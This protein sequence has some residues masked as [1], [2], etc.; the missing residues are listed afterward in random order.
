MTSHATPYL[1]PLGVWLALPEKA[2]AMAERV[3]SSLLPRALRTRLVQRGQA[4]LG[5]Q[6]AP[7][8]TCTWG[9]LG[10]EAL[11]L[12][13]CRWGGVSYSHLIHAA[14]ELNIQVIEDLFAE[15]REDVAP[16]AADAFGSAEETGAAE[17]GGR[18]ADGVGRGL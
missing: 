12:S 9:D 18:L 2:E 3:E 1:P 6:G 13:A 10:A 15:R 8:D 7:L 14:P 5:G 11:R 4:E 17:F 16:G